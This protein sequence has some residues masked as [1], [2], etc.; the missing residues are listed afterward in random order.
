MYRKNVY[1]SYRNKVT[2]EIRQC[3]RD[4]YCSKFKRVRNNMKATWKTIN[5][6]LMNSK[7]KVQYDFIECNGERVHDKQSIVDAFNDF[8]S[9]IGVDTVKDIPDATVDYMQFLPNNDYSQSM[10]MKPIE[11][12]EIFEIVKN[13][14]SN[15]SP[16]YDDISISVLKKSIFTFV[17]PL[18]NIFNMS[19]ENGIFPNALKKAKVIPIFKKGH[20]HILSNYRPISILSTF[21]KIF[22]KLV[23]NRL[24][25][26]LN[27]K[28]I[29]YHK[30]YGFRKQYSTYMA[31]LDFTNTIA[32]AFEKKQVLIGLFLDLTKAFDCINHDIL[33]KK[34]QFYGVRGNVLKWFYSYLDNRVQYV[35]VNNISSAIKH[36]PVG[37]P[38]GS[39]LGP[40]LFLLY[41]NDI[42]FASNI[43]NSIIFADD[44]NL[45]ASGDN[46]DVL[47]TTVNEELKNI[48]AWFVANKLKLNIDKTCWML[49][50]PKNK[51]IDTSL[52]EICIDQ[53]VISFVH[54]VK[55]LGVIIDEKL[56]WKEHIDHVS[57][58]IAKA[59]GAINRIK[60]IVPYNVLVSLYNTMILP[61]ISYCNIVWG[62]CAKTHLNRILVLQ[63]RAI[64]IIFNLQPLSH[65][66][67][68]F[69]KMNCLTIFN[70]HKQQIAIFMFS[71]CHNY[72][73]KFLDDCFI[74]NRSIIKYE[75]RQSNNLYMPNFI[76]EFS[77]STITYAGPKIWN[78]LSNEV[79]QCPSLATFKRKCKEY[80]LNSQNF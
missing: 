77:R 33:I 80:L 37:I 25:S 9:T 59:V 24:M 57:C 38:Q 30:Q 69:R 67:P 55:F 71:Y 46:I 27:D 28:N 8:F 6:I 65:T 78:E 79:K 10:F 48:D 11:L 51:N 14:E 13:L 2:N 43:L 20:K 63:K 32:K 54:S 31:L 22:E 72:L 1:T 4:Y 49:F 3:K 40:L 47:C 18:C 76:Y 42:Q 34:M 21:S 26:F 44:T 45:F 35:S 58:K 36:I 41:V 74:V 56:N 68:Y 50:Q 15:K 7:S 29:L 39:V 73:P 61:H 16:G 60:T 62:N 64:R 70:I 23:Y 17:Q 19:L 12:Y 5:D 52:I 66:A 53:H 75:T